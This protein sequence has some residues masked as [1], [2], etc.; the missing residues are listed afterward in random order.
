M[1]LY[2]LSFFQP[3]LRGEGSVKLT[4][5]QTCITISVSE[6]SKI[7]QEIST[8]LHSFKKSF[9]INN[10]LVNLNTPSDNWNRKKFLLHI[11]KVC[12]ENAKYHSGHFLKR[13]LDASEKPIKIIINDTTA[14]VKR[15][16]VSIKVI[17]K[18][19]HV[20]FDKEEKF[21]FWYFVNF[22]KK[23]DISYDINQKTITFQKIEEALKN[24][25]F[26]MIAKDNILG[27]YMFYSY[28]KF[29]LNVLFHKNNSYSYANNTLDIYEL[30]EHYEILKANKDDTL[31]VI[32][33]KYL[34]LAKRYHPDYQNDLTEHEIKQNTLQ[35]QK[36]QQAYETIKYHKKV[37]A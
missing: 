4:L 5:S 22:F 37:A 23:F 11:Y 13:L 8:T 7:F 27:T 31:E 26:D 10:T 28:S 29:E 25:L 14:P 6:K 18:K 9:W 33:K 36:I 34:R 20:S 17:A 30:K 15:V 1:E 16:C 3:K 21:M 32:R 35:F 2:L 24:A 19:V 12:S